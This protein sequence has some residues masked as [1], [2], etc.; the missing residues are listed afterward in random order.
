L[1]APNPS[2]IVFALDGP[3]APEDV[4]WMCERV[5]SLVQASGTGHVICDVGAVVHPDAV[6]VEALAR[7]QL[8]ARRLGGRLKF[9]NACGELRDLLSVSGLSDVLPCDELTL[10]ARGH[11]E[12]GEPPRGVEE[13]RD[14]ADPVA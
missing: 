12:E 9:Q 7:M 1:A 2:T 14:P 13:E 10:E 11:T 4:R 8:T 5:R 6:T 3:I